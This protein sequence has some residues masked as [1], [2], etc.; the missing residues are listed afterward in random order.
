MTIIF[1]T[2]IVS[3]FAKAN[4]L[5]ILFVLLSGSKLFITP[6]IKDELSIPLEY[7]YSFPEDIFKK[8]GVIIPDI[9]D[10]TEYERLKA[11]YPYLGKGELEALAIAKKKGCIL[12]VNDQKAFEVSLKEGITSIN[13]HTMLKALLKKKILNKEEISV[14][15]NKLEKSDNAV[16]K[17]K[18]YIFE[19]N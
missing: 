8:F 19:E 5:D 10:Y 12:A 18:E 14:L 6:K 15:I 16:I 4:S 13:I 17:G 3:M 11:L 1:D 7:G 2:D 9:D